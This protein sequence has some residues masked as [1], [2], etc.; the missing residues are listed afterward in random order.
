MWFSTSGIFIKQ[1][2]LGPWFTGQS[3]FAYGFAKISDF[4]IAD[5]GTSGV[6]DTAGAKNDT[7][8]TPIF[9][10]YC[11]SYRVVQFAYVFFFIDILFK[12]SQ[13]LS[14]SRSPEPAVSHRTAGAA[15]AVSLTS[16]K[17]RRCR[18]TS[19]IW[20]HIQQGFNPWIRGLG[21]IVLW[22]KPDVENLVTLFL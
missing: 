17:H 20:R 1:S 12:G 6:K 10:C 13:N 15:P 2:N 22:K 11:Y 18:I 21:G 7:K 19:R 5:F 8:I 16:Q 9:W 14:S 4:N 3:L